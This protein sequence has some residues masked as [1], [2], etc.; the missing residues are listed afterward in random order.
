MLAIMV[1]LGTAFVAA[2]VV[3]VLKR[4]LEQAAES[5]KRAW[6]IESVLAL[7]DELLVTLRGGIPETS[8][9]L[10]SQ[11]SVQAVVMLARWRQA[12]TPI[13][14]IQDGCDTVLRP[15]PSEI[16]LRFRQQTT[17]ASVDVVRTS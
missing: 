4:T 5:H 7:D 1:V 9:W 15:R 17:I 13:T 8:C 14:V 16:G 12:H 10:H 6:R 2:R 3:R 11:M